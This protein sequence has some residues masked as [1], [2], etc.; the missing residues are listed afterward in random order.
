MKTRIYEFC[1]AIYLLI[2]TTWP[3]VGS[4]SETIQKCD[5]TKIIQ[6]DFGENTD[7]QA[8][9]GQGAEANNRPRT[10]V[11]DSNANI[12]VGD[13]VNY[14]VVKFD[15][16]GTHM[17]DIP[18]QKPR[19]KEPE[20]GYV[21]SSLAVDKNDNLYVLNF[22]EKQIE[23]YSPAG[24]YLRKFKVRL[25]RPNNMYEDRVD[26]SSEGNIL[27]HSYSHISGSGNGSV[28]S[29]DGLPIKEN[30]EESSPTYF[31]DQKFIRYNGYRL[32]IANK[33]VN[34]DIVDII[35][36]F[37]NNKPV[38]T[39]GPLHLVQDSSYSIDKDGNIFLFESATPN[40]M[41]TLSNSMDVIKTQKFS[42]AR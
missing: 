11:L 8:F 9:S 27:I 15:K 18:L 23:V 21:I 12:Y 16:T 30:I 19:T 13:S 31:N 29:T 1:A 38:G 14:R 5:E 42:G 22:Y 36:L 28:Y 35:T 2:S 3:M 10:L 7:Y 34:G 41:G 40:E 32:E 26:V 6:W 24:K 17:L 39:C 33:P 37:K 20:L 25:S 4:A